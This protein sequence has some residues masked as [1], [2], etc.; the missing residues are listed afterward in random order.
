L[1]KILLWP[2]SGN[3][4][5]KTT[6]AYL[7]TSSTFRSELCCSLCCCLLLDF[8]FSVLT[9]KWTVTW[10]H[11]VQKYKLSKSQKV[12]RSS[13]YIFFWGPLLTGPL[14]R[15]SELWM[16]VRGYKCFIFDNLF[17]GLFIGRLTCAES[18]PWDQTWFR[19]FRINYPIYCSC[20]NCIP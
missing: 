11:G 1:N 16:N 18:R 7:T 3:C 4:K 9:G 12:N 14:I 8:I 15:S 2:A 10:L 17:L 13:Y 5:R 20:Q 6:A 19:W